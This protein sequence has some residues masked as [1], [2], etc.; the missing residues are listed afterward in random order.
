[1]SQ[2]CLIRNEYFSSANLQKKVRFY[3]DRFKDNLDLR[4]RTDIIKQYNKIPYVKKDTKIEEFLLDIVSNVAYTSFEKYDVLQDLKNIIAKNIIIESMYR[5]YF[6]L[7]NDDHIKNKVSDYLKDN[8]DRKD[9][10]LYEIV[11]KS[12]KKGTFGFQSTTSQKEKNVIEKVAEDKQNIHNTLVNSSVVDNVKRLKEKYKNKKINLS[13]INYFTKTI[14]SNVNFQ[15]VKGKIGEVINRILT[16]N[17]TFQEQKMSTIFFYVI[18]EIKEVEEEKKY[19]HIDLCEIIKK[20]LLEMYGK[21]F[22]GHCSRIVNM[23]TG[24]SEDFGVTLSIE[25]QMKT[26]IF[27]ECIKIFKALEEKG[28]EVFGKELYSKLQDVSNISTFKDKIKKEIG[29]NYDEKIFEKCVKLF[30]GL[31]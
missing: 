10:Y 22:M 13:D 11:T 16:D 21:C 12:E 14:F 20:N 19:S 18:S 28:Q 8:L 30:C 23:L 9:T 25:E 3:E 29:K 26:K 24:L 31:V 7:E 27:S 2:S 5:L 17:V 1:M 4:F 6:F 15:D